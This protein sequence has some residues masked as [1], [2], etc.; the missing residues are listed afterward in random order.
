MKK[1]IIVTPADPLTPLQTLKEYF[2]YSTFRP[3]QADIIDSVLSGNDTLV[4]MPTGGGK[5]VCYQL[6]AMMMQGIGI[7]VSPLI[8][9]MKDQVEALRLNGIPAAYINSSQELDSLIRTEQECLS[10]KIKLLYVS[11]E[12][13]QTDGFQNFLSRLQINLF[14]IDEAHCISF[15]GHDFRPEYGQLRVLRKQFPQIPF[16]AL[17]ATADK[18][19]RTDIVQQLGLTN[20]KTFI[21]SFDRPNLSLAVLPAIDRIKHIVR[22]LDEHPRQAGIIYCISRGGTESLAEKLRQ[23]G[24][25]AAAYHA[26][27]SADERN[28][29]QEAFLRDDITIVCATVAFGMGID[30]SNVRFVLHY[31]LPANIESYYQEIGRAGRD[32]L[33][34]KAIMF[35]TISD[36]MQRRKFIEDDGGAVKELKLAKLQLLQ[37]FAEAQLCRRRILLNYFGQ[38][39]GSDCGNCDICRHPKHPF[40][41]TELAQKALSAVARLKEAAPMSTVVD[42]LRGVRTSGVVK[43][44]YDQIKTFGAGK[45]LKP[46]EWSDYIIQLIQLGLLE[47]AYQQHYALTLTPESKAVLFEGK[48]VNLVKNAPPVA[49]EPQKHPKTGK[50][51]ISKTNQQVNDLF[52]RLRQVRKKLA[53]EQKVPAFVVFSDAVLYEMVRYLPQ[54]TDDMLKI[55]GIG[56]R[57]M[58]DYGDIFLK[59]IKDYLNENNQHI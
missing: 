42:V 30:K 7:V 36:V 29:V 51:P 4:L 24:F 26:G 56:F 43:N 14:A 25:N 15:W 1:T 17:T 32:G 39:S 40:D 12:K 8:A 48:R 6:P 28:R 44:R 53:D 46:S 37:R 45:D 11:P 20:A 57:K 55:N 23:R 3:M 5:S 35:Y 34:G 41:G 22:F 33:P 18:V 16:I 2:G 49:S 38:H 21:T 47:I 13:V 10:G 50:Q 59:E 58:T 19:T 31:N 27:L 54:T 52:E 9:L